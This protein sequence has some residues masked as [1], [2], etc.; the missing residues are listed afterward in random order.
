MVCWGS[1]SRGQAAAPAGVSFRQIV[2]GGEHTCGLRLDSTAR[3]WGLNNRGQS[4]PPSSVVFQRLAAG[5]EHTCGLLLNGSVLCWGGNDR[6]GLDYLL[7]S[8]FSTLAAGGYATC[9]RTPAGSAVCWGVT[10]IDPC[11]LPSTVCSLSPMSGCH[12]GG[13][14]LLVLSHPRNSNRQSLRWALKAG[15]TLGLGDFGDPINGTTAYSLCLYEDGELKVASRVGPDPAR[16]RSLPDAYRYKDVQGSSDGFKRLVLRTGPAG[17]SSITGV[18]GGM[19]ARVP[20]PK[21]EQPLLRVRNNVVVQLQQSGGVCY[22]T[23]F[24][25]SHARSLRLRSARLRY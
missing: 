16:W 14:G 4:S 21:P 10:V 7:G 25:P 22:E 24:L 17:R 19:L 18:L 12:A 15:P 11:D 20:N 2:A 1:N 23:E 9:G 6:G 5:E 8:S 13:K 3:C